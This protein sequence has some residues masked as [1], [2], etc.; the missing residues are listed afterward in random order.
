M[1][2]LSLLQIMVRVRD[3]GIRVRDLGIR[4]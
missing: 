2:V 4:D 1:L 3:L